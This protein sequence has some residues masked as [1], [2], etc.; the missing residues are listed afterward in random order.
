MPTPYRRKPHSVRRALPTE[1]PHWLEEGVDGQQLLFDEVTPE[2]FAL[3]QAICSE[4]N[5]LAH[6]GV[7]PTAKPQAILAP[8]AGAFGWQMSFLAKH[9]HVNLWS[10]EDDESFLKAVSQFSCGLFSG[11]IPERFR[12]EIALAL[13]TDS[14]WGSQREFIS[15]VAEVLAVLADDGKA[16]F[17]LRGIADAERVQIVWGDGGVSDL[18]ELCGGDAFLPGIGA[19]TLVEKIDLTRKKY[20]ESEYLSAFLKRHRGFFGKDARETLANRVLGADYQEIVARHE[21]AAFALLITWP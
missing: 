6:T 14:L 15:T 20:L 16:F 11:E 17:C 5:R 19:A 2:L 18:N 13:F 8:P 9:L 1:L 10:G 12:G 21:S 4:I 3:D 7:R